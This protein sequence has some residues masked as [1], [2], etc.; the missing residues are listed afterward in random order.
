MGGETTE[1]SRA[2]PRDV[3]IE[4]AHFDPV[5]D[6]PHRAAGTSCPPRR[7]SGSS[8]ASTRR[9]P[10]VA[11]DRVGR[12]ARRVRRRH[13]RRPASPRRTRRAAPRAD[14][15]RRPT[16]RRGSPAWTST[17]E[18][19]S[20]DLRRP[21]AAGSTADG[22]RRHGHPAALAPRPRPTRTTS[23][24]RSRGSSATTRCPS[25]LPTAAAGRGLTREQ[26]LR[27]RVGRTLAGAGY[28]EVRQLPVRRRRATLDALGLPGRR[29]A[30][31]HGPAGQP[32][33]GGGA[34]AYAP[35]CCPA[36]SSAARAT[37]AAAHADV[38][39]FETGRSPAR[40][41]RAPA[42]IYGVD[43][44]PTDDELGQARRGAARPAAA[45]RG[46]ARRA[47]ASAAG[48][49]GPGRDA[50]WADAVE[51]RPPSGRGARRRR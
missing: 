29:P 17:R 3:V 20:R 5:I 34:A 43:R 51:R 28:V 31:P 37:S 50:D 26:R 38:A 7:P 19:R 18:T 8:A 6:R 13:G 21:S 48:W 45:P 15:D 22:D 47:S 27:R 49:W 40:S 12:A 14:P 25:V 2:R 16:C 42:P 23:S 32:A 11:A 1:M 9:S 33:L 30:P 46:R 24:R 44:R 4:A 39:L 10:R 41:D 35:R 36:C